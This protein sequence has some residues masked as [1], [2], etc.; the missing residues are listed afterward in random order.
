MEQFDKA[1]E[2]YDQAR[3]MYLEVNDTNSSVE[4][5]ASIGYTYQSMK[6]YDTAIS[7]FKK[8]VIEFNKAK[9]YTYI[10]VAYTEIGK[11]YLLKEN[12]DSALVYFK[13][14]GQWYLKNDMQSHQ[15]AQNNYMGQTLVKLK[16]YAEAKPYLE[17]GLRIAEA[18][19]DIQM[20]GE[21]Y[22]GLYDFYNAQGDYKNALTWHEKYLDARDSTNRRMNFEQLA[23]MTTRYETAKK[24][25][26]IAEQKIDINRKKYWLYISLVVLVTA[27]LLGY[28]YYRRFKLKKE[29]Q[30][31]AEVMRQ[32]DLAVK[33]VLEAEEKERKRIA[34]ELHDGVGQMMSAARMNLSAFESD[35][36]P[37]NESQKQKFQQIISLVDESCKE[38]R[39]VSHNMMP[40]ALL[41]SGLANAVRDFIEKIDNR[42]IK[43]DLYSEG[44]NER[45]DANI[46]TV[47]YR[48]IQECVNNVI[49]HSSANHLDISLTRENNTI[50]VTIEDNG[51][52]FDATQKDNFEGI[53]LKNIIT[54]VQYLKGEVDFN[55]S[56]GNGTLVAI[57]VPL[58]SSNI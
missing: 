4:V 18:E 14:A 41:K 46:E 1:I 33:A 39:V 11:T 16:R 58:P 24:D 8:A 55:S 50:S 5:L 19:K 3:H 17:K 35:L 23:N 42:L 52:G 48:V 36:Q 40:N 28:S 44:L 31:Q 22:W 49:K 10:P 53:G 38:V 12:Y 57:H 20:M 26:Q 25:Q 54:R 27:T 47:L 34:G 56:P 15:D 6:K 30:L 32:Q 51:I 45:L 7:I 2:T 21:A 37:A 13:K 9:Y 29:K 43:V